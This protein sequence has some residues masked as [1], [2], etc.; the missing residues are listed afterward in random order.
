MAISPDKVP[1]TFRC[2][3]VLKKELEYLAK[4]DHRTLNK[5]MELVLSDHVEQMRKEG[6]IPDNLPIDDG[7]DK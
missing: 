6:K 5:Y 1:S 3:K 2:T 4:Q 7:S